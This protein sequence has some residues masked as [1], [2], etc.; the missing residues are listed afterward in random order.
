[1]AGSGFASTVRL[2]KS[3]PEMWAPIFTENADNILLVLDRYIANLHKFRDLIKD[4]KEVE[5]NKLMTETNLIRKVLEERPAPV[6]EDT[7]DRQTEISQL[8]N[9]Q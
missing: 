4:G 3:S 5:L 8:T 2:A 6:D 1:M 7:E 9:K